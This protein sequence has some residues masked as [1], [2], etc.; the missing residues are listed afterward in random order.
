MSAN[1]PKRTGGFYGHRT[2]EVYLDEN[3]ERV[4]AP[5]VPLCYDVWVTLSGRAT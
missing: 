4:C 1:D 2:K 3:K 5:L